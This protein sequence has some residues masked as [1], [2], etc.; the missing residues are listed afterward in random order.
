MPSPCAITK[1]RQLLRAAHRP[2]ITT[3]SLASDGARMVACRAAILALTLFFP[4]ASLRAQVPLAEA[5]A[6]SVS[7]R[8]MLSNGNGLPPFALTRGYVLNPGDRVDTRGG[9]QVVIDLSDGSMVV[10]APDSVVVLKDF[11]AA[12]SLRELFEITLGRVRVKINHFGGRPNPYRMNSPTASI[13]VRGTEFSVAVNLMGDTQVVV[14]EGAVE[15]TSLSDPNHRVLIEAGRGV[16]VQAGQD[17]HLFVSPPGAR[18]LGDRDSGDGDHDHHAGGQSPNSAPQHADNHSGPN[19]PPTAYPTPGTPPPGTPPPGSPD[20]HPPHG[21]SDVNSPRAAAG[22]YERYIAS[23]SQIGQTPFLLRFNAFPE[24][25]LDSLENPAYATQFHE[26][27]ARVFFLPSFSGTLAYPGS[28]SFVSPGT[29][30]STYSISPQFTIF[31]PIGSSGVVIGGGITSSR[32]GSGS[33]GLTPDLEAGIFGYTPGTNP[34]R[35]TGSSVGSYWSGSLVLAR[36]FGA[37]GN[38]SFGLEIERL[39]GNGSLVNN[40]FDSDVPGQISVDTIHSLS[41]ISQ[42]RLTAGL[43]HD[44][45]GGHKLGVFYRYSWIEATD[46]D[47]SN[48]LDGVSQSLNNTSSA[49]HSG[50]LGMRLRGPLSSRLFYGVDASFIGLSLNDGLVRTGAVDSQQRDRARRGALGLGLGYFLTPRVILSFD[51]VGGSSRLEALRT[52]NATGAL[53]QSGSGDSRFVSLHG[54]LQADLTRR[55]FVDASLLTVWT[56]SSIGF[57]VFPD[58]FGNQMLIGDSF[59]PIPPTPFQPVGHYSDFGVGWRFSPQFFAQ[60][61]YSTDYGYTAASH[62]LMLRYTFRLHKE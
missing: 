61:V 35:V 40:T 31:T 2:S 37:S 49:G 7:G 42:T 44:F 43:S 18:D 20:T 57:S 60:Y 28:S 16:L 53:L 39:I 5:R 41:N 21:D 54:A 34:L 32:V 52:E 58:Q 14:F 30:P 36:R 48:I 15:V 24:A 46:G 26:G 17:F 55:L 6:A 56:G 9:G 11:R 8:V 33:Q 51:L 62:T 13:A 25:H 38:N 10:V 27:E 47:T 4:A 19:P 29:Q 12:S 23:L 22:T 1:T 59:F 45:A 3:R 50:E